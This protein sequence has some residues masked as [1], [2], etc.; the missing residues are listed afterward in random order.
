MPCQ[1]TFVCRYKLKEYKAVKFI[2]F[3]AKLAL[4]STIGLGYSC[5]FGL[6]VILCIIL[7]TLNT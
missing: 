4:I 7:I 3:R 1:S 2:I 6:A 5:N